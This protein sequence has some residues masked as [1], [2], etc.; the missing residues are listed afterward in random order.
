MNEQPIRVLHVIG[1]MNRGG[2]EA[3]IMNLYRSINRDRVQF[4]FVENSTEP[5]AFDAEILALGGRIYRCPHYSGKNHFRYRKWWETFF[6][7][8]AGEYAVVHGHLGSTAAI[9]LSTAKRFGLYTVAH[10]HGRNGRASLRQAAYSTLSFPTRYIADCFFA[11]SVAAG[12]DRF[13]K[14][15]MSDPERSI[16]LNNAVDTERFRYDE[17]TRTKKRGELG[18]SGCDYVIGHVG[19]FD[20]AKNQ[21]FLLDI[22]AEICKADR[23][24]R[25]ILVGDGPLKQ[26]NEKKAQHLQISDK[27]IFT[28]IRADVAELMQAMDIFVFPS[29]N[30]GLPVT[31]VEAQTAGLPCVISDGVPEDSIITE[32]LVTVRR[33]DEDA[34]AWARHILS[35]R[36]EARRDHSEEV[37]A[38][39]F[40]IKENAKWL[41]AFYLEKSK[42]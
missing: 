32:A 29:Y 27:V 15:V 26:E 23:N 40:D 36:S 28:G 7:E 35:R 6:R 18:Y 38:A 31:L 4:D 10:S 8:H 33:L 2:A 21:A 1:I 12:R 17:G 19:R 3:M 11:C 37:A 13:G 16:L 24:A 5:A 20:R 9:Y 30:E 34:A 22:F 42:R 25:L 39:G 14:K 41:E